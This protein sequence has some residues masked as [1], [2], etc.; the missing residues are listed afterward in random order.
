MPKITD[1]SSTPATSQSISN[2]GQ[3]IKLT[4]TNVF[5]FLKALVDKGYRASKTL[6]IKDGSILYRYFEILSGNIK[7]TEE[8]P[9]FPQLY[10]NMLNAIAKANE[11]GA[12]DTNDAAVIDR[13]LTY[14]N[15]HMAEKFG[16]ESGEQ[17]SLEL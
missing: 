4:N 2:N 7:P 8:D 9:T 10:Q 14:V 11:D 1:A 15:E 13:L 16:I 5:Q 12:Y 3:E 17:Q 6:T